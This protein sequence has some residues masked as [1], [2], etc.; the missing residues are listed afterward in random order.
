[1]TKGSA[2][3]RSQSRGFSEALSRLLQTGHEF[4]T[5]RFAGN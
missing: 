4:K 5:A 1:M 2:A 3:F